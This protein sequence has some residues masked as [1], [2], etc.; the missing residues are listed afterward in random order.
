MLVPLVSKGEMADLVYFLILLMGTKALPSALASNYLS[1]FLLGL[2]FN[3]VPYEYAH[4]YASTIFICLRI[5]RRILSGRSS[6]C[7]VLHFLSTS[8]NSFSCELC[9]MRVQ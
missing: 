5:H 4:D 7:I 8:A 2:L 9:S 3:Y 1:W 6:R